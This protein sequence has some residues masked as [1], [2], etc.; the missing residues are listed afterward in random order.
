MKKALMLLLGLVLVS[1]AFASVRTDGMGIMPVQDNDIDLIWV[2]PQAIDDYAVVDYRMGWLDGVDDNWGGVIHRDKCIGNW[3]VYLGRP[4]MGNY[5]GVDY[6][7]AAMGGSILTG[8]GSWDGIMSYMDTYIANWGV[9]DPQN[10][11]DLFKTFKAGNGVLGLRINYATNND[12]DDDDLET[13]TENDANGY[14]PG[15]QISWEDNF[16]ENVIGVDLGY[17]MKKLGPFNNF[18]MAVGYSIGSY[19]NDD[20]YIY[21][22]A[23]DT[24]PIEHSHYDFEG[25]G[26]SEMRLA[27]RGVKEMTDVTKLVVNGNLKMGKLAFKYDARLDTDNDGVLGE[28]AGEYDSATEEY[29]NTSFGLGVNCVHTVHDGWGKVVAGLNLSSSKGTWNSTEYTSLAG[30]VV[31]D[32]IVDTGENFEEETLSNMSIWANIGV[33][34]NLLKWLQIRGGFNKDIMGKSKWTEMVPTTVVTNAYQSVANAEETWT[35]LNDVLMTFG[36][37]I[38]YKNWNIDL[39]TTTESIEDFM[40]DA[41][42]G[43]GILY[44]GHVL[45]DIVM[46]QLTYNL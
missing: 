27:L 16:G 7:D 1:P 43:S 6:L 20:N 12:E 44:Q 5:M 34:A 41:T 38:T 40:G 46:G 17:G 18:D 15:E 31:A 35:D 30:S 32:Q 24:G 25:D 10:K 28:V 42:L 14:E 21:Q 26:I 23:A 13:W 29:K 39:L 45:N 11:V 3:G 37:G 4:F 19:K 36:I 9:A 2:F 8:A 33:E 22:N